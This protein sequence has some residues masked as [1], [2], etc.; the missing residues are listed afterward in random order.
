MMKTIAFVLGLTI[1]GV[2]VAAGV[3]DMYSRAELTRDQSRYRERIERLYEDG[4]RQFMDRPE[5]QAILGTRI[6]LPLKGQ[7]PLDAY[8]NASEKVVTLPVSSL[9]FI[10]NLSVA[11]AWRYVKRYSL[12]PMDE[13]LAML[14]YRKPEDF[15]SGRV[16]APPA[17]LGVPS[18]IWERDE[19]VRDLYLSF[20]NTAWAFILA[21]ELAHVRFDHPGNTGAPPAVSQR[22]ELQADAFAVD[23]RS[24]SD[25]ILMGAILWFQASVGYFK[26]RADFSTDAGYRDWGRGKATHPVNADRLIRFGA[27]LSRAADRTLSRGHASAL[28]VI[29]MQVT[30]IADILA[31]PDM[32][33]LI[34]RCAVLGDPNDLKRLQDRPCDK[35]LR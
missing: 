24:R 7:G 25:T 28:R 5:K 23:L 4:L 16:P 32:Q 13:Y 18:K 27:A 14:K 1:P 6:Q 30:Q 10:E 20:R 8:S 19:E 3:E 11:Y 33:R 26:N 31:E 17:A 35:R 34:A 21:H 2:L 29:A 22:N 9:K 12:E 15:P